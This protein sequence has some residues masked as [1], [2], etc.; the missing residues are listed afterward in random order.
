MTHRNAL[1]TWCQ[2]HEPAIFCRELTTAL[3]LSV[4]ILLLD[5]HI[6]F[7]FFSFTYI[8]VCNTFQRLNKLLFKRQHYNS[9]YTP[10]F[11]TETEYYNVVSKSERMCFFVKYVNIERLLKETELERLC[12]A[13]L[14]SRP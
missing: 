6:F 10:R 7:L 14:L 8:P 3:H 4:W 12:N 9:I 5:L 2:S 13:P 1:L 11:F